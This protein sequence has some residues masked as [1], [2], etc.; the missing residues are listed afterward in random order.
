VRRLLAILAFVGCAAVP[1]TDR[2]AAVSDAPLVQLDDAQVEAIAAMALACVEQEYPNKI[3]HVLASDADA[4]PPRELTPAFYGCFDWHSAVHG[5]WL[6]ARVARRHPTTKAAA[7]AREVLAR[8]LT[9]ERIAGEVAYLGRADRS[10]FERPYGLAWLLQLAA[11]LHAWDDPDA[12]AWAQA[13]APLERSARDRML[14]WLPKLTHPIRVGEHNQTAF[15]MGLAIDWARATGD[16]EALA[17]LVERARAFHGD[18]RGCD[19]AFE[20]SGHDF[21]SPCLGA[22]DLMRRVLT[23]PELGAWLSRALPA[24]R[25][26]GTPFLHPVAPTD[27]SDG[28]LVHLDGLALSRAWM[29]DGIAR[30]LPESDPRRASLRATA[31]EHADAGLGALAGQHYE[32]AHWL[33]TFAMMLASD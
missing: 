21:L 13:L 8:H 29:L 5:H 32:G 7:R 11:E 15:A 26:D 18:D 1:R 2:S 14:E 22:A 19:L 9:A 12:R 10:G 33:G 4:R 23:A 28:K 31:R 25:T 6:L 27:R 20:P 16:D 17:V 30:G 3:A 24:V